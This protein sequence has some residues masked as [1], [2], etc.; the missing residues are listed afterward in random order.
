MSRL[1]LA[2]SCPQCTGSTSQPTAST[3][4]SVSCKRARRAAAIKCGVK[5]RGISTK[6]QHDGW[7][8][9]RMVLGMEGLNRSPMINTEQ[10]AGA[11][12][13]KWERGARLNV[14][15]AVFRENQLASCSYRPNCSQLLVDTASSASHC[16]SLFEASSI[17]HYQILDS[18]HGFLGEEPHT[19]SWRGSGAP[20][21]QNEQHAVP[22]EH[23]RPQQQCPKRLTLDP[24]PTAETSALPVQDGRGADGRRHP[25]RRRDE[26]C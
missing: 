23:G 24:T 1:C 19:E 20:E 7:S 17:Y 5:P 21:F 26:H 18:H 6:A 10:P 15:E 25:A 9:G 12:S 22:T 3:Y 14:P 4:A 2:C 13:N 11:R 16:A 8:E